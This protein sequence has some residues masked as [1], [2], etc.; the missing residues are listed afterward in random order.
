MCFY[1]FKFQRNSTFN[2]ISELVLGL[3][4]FFS[5]QHSVIL[6]LCRL[7]HI[8]YLGLRENASFTIMNATPCFAT[9]FSKASFGYTNIIYQSWFTFNPDLKDRELHLI[10]TLYRQ[11]KP[12]MRGKTAAAVWAPA[13]LFRYP[14]VIRTE[15]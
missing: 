1:T 11:H 3:D 6:Q 8:H 9:V 12:Q 4:F 13:A 15:I 14:T 2:F 10:K 7:H 5:S